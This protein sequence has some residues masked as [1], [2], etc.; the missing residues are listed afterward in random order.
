MY[1]TPF[2]DNA[3]PTHYLATIPSTHPCFCN[4]PPSTHLSV[5][6]Y[7]THF[8]PTPFS[9]LIFQGQHLSHPHTPFSDC[10]LHPLFTNTLLPTHLSGTTSLPPTHTFQRLLLSGDK[11]HL[12]PQGQSND[13]TG[14]LLLLL[15][16]HSLHTLI[17]GEYLS[18][19]FIAQ[20]FRG[21]RTTTRIWWTE[22]R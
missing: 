12:V 10:L 4:A 1:C 2:S 3:S 13:K 5:T 9:P 14:V 20:G 19:S 21:G 8:S 18:H 16:L 15:Q 7:S 11:Q 22:M 17:K 6:V